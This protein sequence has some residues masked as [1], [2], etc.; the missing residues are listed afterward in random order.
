MTAHWGV[1]DPAEVEGDENT[2]R[3]AFRDALLVLRRRI[4][5]LAA[6]PADGLDRLALERRVRE[7]GTR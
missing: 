6:L 3:R 2:R 5:L 1:P 4:D 7:I